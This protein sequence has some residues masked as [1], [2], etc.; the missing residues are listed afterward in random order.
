MSETKERLEQLYIQLQSH[1]ETMSAKDIMR[2]FEL[3]DSKDLK[4]SFN[5]LLKRLIKIFIQ[6]GTQ[7]SI[8]AANFLSAYRKHMTGIDQKPFV[9]N[10]FFDPT[11]DKETMKQIIQ[12]AYFCSQVVPKKA[13][14]NG[15]SVK[16]AIDKSKRMTVAEMN[17]LLHRV[18][19]KTINNTN[20]LDQ[21]A[22]DLFKRMRVN[23]LK[24]FYRYVYSQK[25]VK[26]F[27]DLIKL[28]KSH[29]GLFDSAVS[30]YNTQVLGK[31]LREQ[32]S[33]RIKSLLRHKKGMLMRVVNPGACDYCKRLGARTFRGRLD[34]R[35]SA[36][37]HCR[38]VFT[39]QYRELLT[40]VRSD[41]YKTG[42]GKEGLT[43]ST[44]SGWDAWRIRNR[45]E[46]AY[47]EELM[48]MN[49]LVY[50]KF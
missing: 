41:E 21:T 18:G 50:D 4:R 36:H 26:S 5:P 37:P 7:Q 10:K 32:Y 13:I 9:S 3:L 20:I 30:S 45:F 22:V 48:K 27:E 42:K 40:S 47:L 35:L 44:K 39:P 16:D 38:C 24:D 11:I 25:Q 49:Y 43:Q 28:W 2:A 6:R 29:P 33:G 46:K 23:G 31:L 12:R 34:A 1:I 19:Y 8:A 17:D 14:S 15:T